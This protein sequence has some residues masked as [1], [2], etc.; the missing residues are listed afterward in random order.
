[1][2][3]TLNPVKLLHK[4]GYLVTD[5]KKAEVLDIFASVS[6]AET[7][8]QESQTWEIRERVCRKEDLSLVNESLVTDHLRNLDAHK[9]MGPDEV[10]PQVLRELA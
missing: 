6:T 4:V 3:Q 1:M 9:P 8:P 5:N 7:A 2:S 10:H